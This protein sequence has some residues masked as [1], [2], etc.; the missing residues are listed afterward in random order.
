[1]IKGKARRWGVTCQC[2]VWGVG[3]GKVGGGGRWETRDSRETRAT[4]C[5][6]SAEAFCA[7]SHT[8][9]SR[10][11]THRAIAARCALGRTCALNVNCLLFPKNGI[12]GAET[13]DVLWCE[14]G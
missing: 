3:T 10:I 2:S 9:G 5:L 14:S 1:M 4:S 13:W 6:R 7:T 12:G 11:A 8:G